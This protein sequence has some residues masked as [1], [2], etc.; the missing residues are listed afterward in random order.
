LGQK[1]YLPGFIIT[2][3]GDTI[4]G[5]LDYRNWERN[6]KKIGFKANGSTETID[7]SPATIIG[8][9]VADEIYMSAVIETEI[10]SDKT[11]DL[12]FDPSLNIV[13]DSGFLQL[14][15]RGEKNLY[16]F[17]NRLGKEQYYTGQISAPELLVYKRY[18]KMQ[19]GSSVVVENKKYIGQLSIYLSDCQAIQPKLQ[20]TQ[21]QQNSLE[22]L[23]LAYYDCM[24]AP[25][26][27]YKK[28][29]NVTLAFG[30]IAGASYTSLTF[31]S[32]DFVYLVD[33]G[34]KPSY[35]FT[36]G[37]YMDVI[38]ARNSGKW[39]ICNELLYTNYRVDGE[40]TDYTNENKY[41]VY[42]SR[43]GYM[44]LK[45]NNLIRFKLPVGKVFLYANVGIS[46]GLAIVEQNQMTVTSKL[47]EQV[48][49]EE[50][51]A[52]D[53]TRKYEVGFLGGLG[54]NYGRFSLEARYEYGTGMSTYNSLR[55][56]VNRVYLFLGFRF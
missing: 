17:R 56:P 41:T 30:V 43:L 20:N 2:L 21:Y 15:I 12:S 29:D 37:V 6:P 45:L 7:Y 46:N 23:F 53:D 8:F 54:G 11:G 4:R 36:G 19:G 33:A 49:V 26:L 39:S 13:M 38:L 51:K 5:T 50:K 14:L 22:K 32:A 35:S 52:L 44:Y 34:Y 31:H 47:Y 1:N 9:G 18:L 3:T 24:N 27:F 55:S 40:Y 25:L 42:S 10:S 16:L 28:P 48:R